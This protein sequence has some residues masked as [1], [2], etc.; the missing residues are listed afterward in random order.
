MAEKITPVLP[1]VGDEVTIFGV[2]GQVENVEPF[3]DWFWSVDVHV[4]DS[5]D[6]IAVMQVLIPTDIRID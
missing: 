5:G 1:E 4:R 3:S 2:T 6:G